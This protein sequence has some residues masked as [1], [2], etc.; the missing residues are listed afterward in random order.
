MKLLY[1]QTARIS[2]KD[3]EDIARGLESYISHLRKAASDS[4]YSFN[5]SSIF[6]PFDEEMIKTVLK[7]KDEYVTEKLKHLILI[8]IGGSELGAKAILD[9]LPSPKIE[10][11]YMDTIWRVPEIVFKNPEEVLVTVVC[12]SGST[13]ETTRNMEMLLEK[14][15]N[16]KTRLVYISSNPAKDPKLL[17]PEK[18]GG[19]FSVFSAAGLFPLAAAG[20]DIFGLLEGAM[21]ARKYSLT[22]TLEDNYALIT[23]GLTFLH[24]KEGRDIKINFMFHPQL[25]SLGNWYQQL[26]AESLGKDGKGITPITS[27]GTVD[28]HSVLQLYLEG[29]HDKFTEFVYSPKDLTKEISRILEGVKNSYE[30]RSLPYIDT[31]LDPISEKSLGHYMQHKMLEAMFLGKLFNV[32]TFDQPAVE[33]YRKFASS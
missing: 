20:V 1:K 3:L 6:L 8:G 7:V 13:L 28:L 11:T 17:I 25:V 12:K 21:E 9:A 4:D 22:D 33:E 14:Y 15:P 27:L 2:E 10:I 31:L 5:E 18:V 19:R 30:T 26:L 16:L 32:H 23:A 29:P 24:A